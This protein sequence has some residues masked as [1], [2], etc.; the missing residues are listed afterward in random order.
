MPSG[1]DLG[2]GQLKQGEMCLRF[3]TRVLLTT[4]VLDTPSQVQEW[5]YTKTGAVRNGDS[6]ISSEGER[7]VVTAGRCDDGAAAQVGVV[8]R[9]WIRRNRFI[10]HSATGLCLDS[11]HAPNVTVSKCRRNLYSQQWD[12]SVELQAADILSAR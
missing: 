5:V 7:W 8:N 2:L 1:D 10:I 6:C 9:K 11:A 12:F 3:D 4:C